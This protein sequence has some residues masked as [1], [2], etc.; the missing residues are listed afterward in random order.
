M[1]LRAVAY[2]GWLPAMLLNLGAATITLRWRFYR[3]LRQGSAA[4]LFGA[5]VVCTVV[6]G[7]P[8]KADAAFVVGI[9]LPRQLS[10]PGNGR[11]GQ[12][13]LIGHP[14]EK[15]D[16]LFASDNFMQFRAMEVAKLHTDFLPWANQDGV[17][18]NGVPFYNIK[19]IGDDCGIN[20][21]AMPHSDV[22]C[23]RTPTVFDDQRNRIAI[24]YFWGWRIW[25]SDYV[26]INVGAQL[27]ISGSLSVNQGV[28]GNAPEFAGGPPQRASEGGD[29]NARKSSNDFFIVIDEFKRLSP[30]EQQK[31]LGGALF[32][33]GL[34]MIC[35]VIYVVGNK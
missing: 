12:N 32:Y 19:W 5:I 2:P 26:E 27:A 25:A 35:A 31:V 18:F 9:E 10:L 23:P 28:I 16:T 15:K 20:T 6:C 7:H 3:W 8:T 14:R 30:D 17:R 24:S 33:V 4:L 11:V 34:I 29:G 13:I 1:E 21:P 22:T